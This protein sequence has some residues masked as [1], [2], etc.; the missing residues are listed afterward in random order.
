M[1]V[2]VVMSLKETLEKI[3]S[4]TFS[5]EI[6]GLGYVGF[7]LAVR[8]ATNGIRVTGIDIFCK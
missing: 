4:K 7:P 5:V 8:L 2:E 1:K 6:L 3:N